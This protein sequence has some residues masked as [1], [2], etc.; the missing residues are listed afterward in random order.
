MALNNFNMFA[1][2]F[3]T[4]FDFLCAPEAD[5]TGQLLDMERIPKRGRRRLLKDE[6]E[7]GGNALAGEEPP[8]PSM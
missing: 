4:P 1:L 3:N 6:D 2:G 8:G 7:L 5:E